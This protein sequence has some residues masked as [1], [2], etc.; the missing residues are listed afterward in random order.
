MLSPLETMRHYSPY[1]ISLASLFLSACTSAPRS[2][3]SAQVTRVDMPHLVSTPVEKLTEKEKTLEERCRI[4]PDEMIPVSVNK[5]DVGLPSQW[6]ADEEKEI[7]ELSQKPWEEV[8]EVIRT[9]RQAAIYCRRLLTHGN[10]G[11]PFGEFSI[12]NERFGC[13]YWMSGEYTHELK[14]VD[15][16]D[17]AVTAAS[18]LK[19]NGFGAYILCVQGKTKIPYGAGM[20]RGLIEKDFG[21]A[22]FIY[23][24]HEGK[25][26]TVGINENDIVLPEASSIDAFLSTWSTMTN[27][28]Y[29][30]W[31]IYDIARAYPDYDTNRRN[32]NPSAD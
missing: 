11:K 29:E 6:S 5:F 2:Y 10:H 7:H 20:A 28:Q 15:C 14:I 30:S 31:V 25:L 16:D 26:G 24:T 13:D 27:D 8:Q 22:V 9:P 18:L 21:H 12:D 32:N 17:S 19:D 1:L 3:N 23:K 4:T